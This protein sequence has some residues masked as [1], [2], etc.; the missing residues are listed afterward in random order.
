MT[1]ITEKFSHEC[2]ARIGLLG[3]P[4]DAYHGQC[5][6]LAID[7]FSARVRLICGCDWHERTA[8]PPELGP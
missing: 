1:K 3:N 5:L 7:N 8:G 2:P 4:S 6:S